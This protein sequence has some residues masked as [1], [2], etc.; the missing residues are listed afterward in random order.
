MIAIDRRGVRFGT[1]IHEAGHAIVMWA[2]GLTVGMIEIGIG[3]DDTKGNAASL[4]PD[5]HLPLIDRIAIC[6]AGIEAQ[7][8]FDCPTH[9]L[10]GALDLG[11]VVELLDGIP[12]PGA[13]EMR[14]AGYAR[15]RALILMHKANSL[16]VAERL[17]VDDG[18]VTADEF[19]M[20]I[21]NN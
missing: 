11:K 2:L 8:I 14:Q 17:V 4:S 12:E 19:A 3:G 16:R 10:A 5:E 21:N 13:Y 18:K 7:H 1:A 15:A 6:V 9:E 20:L